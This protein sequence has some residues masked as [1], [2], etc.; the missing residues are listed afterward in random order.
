MPFLGFSQDSDHKSKRLLLSTSS[1]S[2]PGMIWRHDQ[3]SQGVTARYSPLAG[4]AWL[5]WLRAV[6]LCP[7]RGDTELCFSQL[8][9]GDH[10]ESFYCTISP[11]AQSNHLTLFHWDIEKVLNPTVKRRYPFLWCHDDADGLS[12]SFYTSAHAGYVT[13]RTAELPSPENICLKWPQIKIF[14]WP[15]QWPLRAKSL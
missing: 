15:L 2:F 7:P 13:R 4:L 11:M 6:E 3:K 5:W 8:E 12:L 1:S 9:V 10:T 14:T